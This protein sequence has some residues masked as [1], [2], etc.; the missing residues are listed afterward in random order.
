MADCISESKELSD[1]ALKN[2][3]QLLVRSKYPSSSP[4]PGSADEQN[5]N[6]AEP[7]PIDVLTCEI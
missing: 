1:K 2:D 6:V 4:S 5:K 3:W 7:L